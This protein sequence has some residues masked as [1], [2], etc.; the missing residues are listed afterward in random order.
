MLASRR[1]EEEALCAV[2]AEGHSVDAN[3]IVFCERC[4]LAVHQLCYG[5]EHIPAGER[6]G[7]RAHGCA[8]APLCCPPSQ[9]PSP[10]L[11][12]NL[13]LGRRG[14]FLGSAEEQDQKERAYAL[15]KAEIRE[16][17]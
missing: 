7:L 8:T 15:G 10:H 1:G 16:G 9:L 4:D 3:V 17:L 2:C 6:S 13:L 14:V 12:H 11:Q 5:I